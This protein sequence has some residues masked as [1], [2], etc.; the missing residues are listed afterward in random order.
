MGY[1]ASEKVQKTATKIL[2]TL[3]HL[4]HIYK[5]I[6]KQI[7]TADTLEE[8]WQTYKIATGRHN[9]DAA[10]S[11]IDPGKRLNVGNIANQRKWIATVQKL[12]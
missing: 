9:I 5:I 1:K 11:V 12:S 7:N 4:L 10:M 6:W 3:K 8:K 2:C